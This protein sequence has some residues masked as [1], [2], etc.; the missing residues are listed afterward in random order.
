MLV[1]LWQLDNVFHDLVAAGIG[2]KVTLAECILDYCPK[3]LQ[4]REGSRVA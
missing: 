3:Q 4:S 1:V 2:C